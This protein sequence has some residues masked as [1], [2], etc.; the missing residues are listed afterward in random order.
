MN[1][2]SDCIEKEIVMP[3]FMTLFRHSLLKSGFFYK[4]KAYKKGNYT[5]LH[6]RTLIYNLRDNTNKR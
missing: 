4:N 5:H 3:Y 6:I 2:D 1:G